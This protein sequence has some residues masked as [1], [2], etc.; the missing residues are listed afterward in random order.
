MP[1]R[2][3]GVQ[4][5]FVGTATPDFM[6]DE[7]R[8]SQ[9][10]WNARFSEGGFDDQLFFADSNGLFS[11]TSRNQQ[12]IINESH[13]IQAQPDAGLLDREATPLSGVSLDKNVA[14]ESDISESGAT[15]SDC[16]IRIADFNVSSNLSTPDSERAVA[17][18]EVFNFEGVSLESFQFLSDLL[19]D[20]DGLVGANTFFEA[21]AALRQGQ[22]QQNQS[23]VQHESSADSSSATLSRH[24]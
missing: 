2:Q 9:Q 18:R 24:R 4:L 20:W 21:A 6:M 13:A 19:S 8:H 12:A 11:A 23:T 7:N 15:I 16:P 22:V 14:Y 1:D 5:R 3:G 10:N 17:D